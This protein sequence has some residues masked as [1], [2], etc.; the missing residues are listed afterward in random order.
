MS[1]SDILDMCIPFEGD[2][3]DDCSKLLTMLYAQ[4]IQHVRLNLNEAAKNIV[5][6]ERELRVKRPQ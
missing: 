5:R 6:I 2:I 4:S 3:G 1:K